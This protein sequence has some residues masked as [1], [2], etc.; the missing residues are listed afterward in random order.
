MMMPM[1]LAR[2]PTSILSAMKFIGLLAFFHCQIAE[3]IDDG[4]VLQIAKLAGVE[5]RAAAHG[6]MLEPDVRLFQIYHANHP[7]AAARTVD[8]VYFVELAT[9]L[10]VADVNRLGA[11]QLPQ[12]L[13]LELIEEEALAARAAVHFDTGEIDCD[14]RRDAF[15]TVHKLGGKL[16]WTGFVGNDQS[17]IFLSLAHKHGIVGA[18]AIAFRASNGSVDL[19]AR[20]G[21]MS[22]IGCPAISTSY[23]FYNGTS[24]SVSASRNLANAQPDLP[25]C[26]DVRKNR[27]DHTRS[28]GS[29][30]QCD[31]QRSHS[32]PPSAL[33][34][35]W[36]NQLSQR[37]LVPQQPAAEVS[38]ILRRNSAMRDGA[39]EPC[40][41]CRQ[42]AGSTLLHRP[43]RPAPGQISSR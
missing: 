4:V 37:E 12:L 41:F 29:W 27:I 36:D 10:R 33:R 5:E 7:A 35:H 26:N 19:S 25:R 2:S 1:Y 24:L 13:L 15:W 42:D 38:S 8:E 3:E 22:L 30:S 43:R 11:F 34:M 32:E 9:D 20:I 18:L 28:G 16:K 17:I 14:H 39:A 40:L 6:A 23:Y 31:V 21:F